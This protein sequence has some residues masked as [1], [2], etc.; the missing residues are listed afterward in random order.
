MYSTIPPEIVAGA[1]QMAVYFAT[2]FAMLVSLMLTARW[3]A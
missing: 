3:S 2:A 1:A